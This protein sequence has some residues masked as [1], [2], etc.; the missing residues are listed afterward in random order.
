MEGENQKMERNESGSFQEP[1]SENYDEREGLVNLGAIRERARI[2]LSDIDNAL[3]KIPSEIEGDEFKTEDLEH[4]FKWVGSGEGS[5]IVNLE[6]TFI[7]NLHNFRERLNYYLSSTKHLLDSEKPIEVDRPSSMQDYI[8]ETALFRRAVIDASIFLK[9]MC[10]GKLYCCSSWR[11][12]ALKWTGKEWKKMEVKWMRKG[13][14]GNGEEI[15][16]Y[17]NVEV[18]GKKK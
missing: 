2:F 3:E 1:V 18:D 6:E 5:K 17:E 12:A 11:P 8:S 9:A 4:S 10:D 13:V 15:G 14:N 16:S 7:W